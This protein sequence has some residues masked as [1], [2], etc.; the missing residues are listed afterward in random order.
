MSIR[1]RAAVVGIGETDYSKKSGRTELALACAAINT[2][3]A[4]AGLSVDDVDGVVRFEMDAIDDVALTQHLGLKNLR[5]MGLTGY[6]GTG[7]NAAIVHAAAAISAGLA[8]TVVCYRALNERSGVRYGQAATWMRDAVGGFAAFQMPW[9]LLTPAQAFAMF[10]QR[11]M[12][13]YG[14][15]SEQFGAV[16]VA[17]RHHATLN[18]RAM[19]T[20]PITLEDHQSSRMITSPLRLLDCCI[21]SDGACAVVV[22]STERA[23]D[24]KQKPAMIAGGAQAS[25]SRA[26]GIVFRDRLD[27]AESTFAARDLYAASGLGPEDVDAVMI[28]DHF[29]PFVIFSLEAFG[30]CPIGEG[31][32]FVADGHTRIGGKLPVNTHGGSL[33]EAYIHGLN[34]VVEATRQIRGQ[35]S[36]QVEGAEVVLSCSSVAQ[37]ASAVMLTRD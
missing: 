32:R 11:H 18:P 7:A 17:T 23:R 31:G 21:E 36:A 10:A 12:S 2:A 14:T 35:S 24:L 1:Y 4:D 5:Y 13:E 20:K 8:S 15:T 16:S 3:L 34:H 29:S 22:T 6:G 26:Q 9:G 30:F 27:V 19:M 28:Y 25:G 37:L 33:S